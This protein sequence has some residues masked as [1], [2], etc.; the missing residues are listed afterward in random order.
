MPDMSGLTG[1]RTKKAGAYVLATLIAF[2]AAGGGA[3]DLYDR[4]IDAPPTP[5]PAPTPI[6]AC[7]IQGA[8]LNPD[9]GK[10]WINVAVG[11]VGSPR[12]EAKTD[13]RGAFSFGCGHIDPGSFPLQLTAS[14]DTW[15]ACTIETGQFVSDPLGTR[16]VVIYVSDRIGVPAC[17]STPSGPSTPGTPVLQS[18][19]GTPVPQGTT[20]TPAPQGTPA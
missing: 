18:T 4:F 1:P 3:V 16:G 11:Y 2:L 15:G 6:R 9:T 13:L 10:G 12:H 20:G 17:P 19:P 7:S 8:V 5:E 14:S